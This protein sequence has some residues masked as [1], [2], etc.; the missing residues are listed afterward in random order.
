LLPTT[1]GEE[2]AYRVAYA[3]HKVPES[4]SKV[5]DIDSLPQTELENKSTDFIGVVNMHSV[6]AHDLPLPE[7]LSL[8]GSTAAG[9]LRVEVAYM[10]LPRGWGKGYATEAVNAMV[11]ACQRARAFWMPFSKLHIRGI[12]NAGNP[13]S[14]RVMEKTGMVKTGVYEWTGKAIFLAGEWR[15]KD[16]IHIFGKYL[17]LIE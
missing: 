14:L 2:H 15:E 3:V 11:G 17:D 13:A 5:V 12:V 1:E 10:F 8:P 7:N 16:T 6:G 4:T 9:T